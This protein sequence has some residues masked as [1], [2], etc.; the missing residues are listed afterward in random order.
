MSSPWPTL[1]L[2][3]LYYYMVRFA[4]PTYMKGKPAFDVQKLMFAY[5][6]LQTLF[7]LW[8]FSRYNIT[9]MSMINFYIF[10]H[11][12]SASFG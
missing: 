2:C 8:I 1:G 5:N 10:A 7:S 11:L 6:F 4:G 12:D 9:S 3:L